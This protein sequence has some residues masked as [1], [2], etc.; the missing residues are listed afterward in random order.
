MTSNPNQVA[1]TAQWKRFNDEFFSLHAS[2]SVRP[3]AIL[4]DLV[5]NGIEL[6]VDARPGP[7][8]EARAMET[9]CEQAGVYYVPA[10][11]AR[12]IVDLSEETIARYA[13][14]ALRHKTCVVIDDDAVGLLSLI[15]EQRCIKAT[16][17][18]DGHDEPPEVRA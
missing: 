13:N 18:D 6:V 15:A 4:A 9:G 17:L 14:L 8:G 10:P 2:F 7:E 3:D 1:G 5:A 11:G 16:P 12:T